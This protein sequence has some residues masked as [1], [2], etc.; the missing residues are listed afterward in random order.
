[1]SSFKSYDLPENYFNSRFGT[2]I[3]NLEKYETDELDRFAMFSH[4]KNAHLTIIGAGGI[5]SHLAMLAATSGMRKI[6]IID[7][8][9]VEESN[10]IRQY[11][12][13]ESEVH[14]K[15]KGKALSERIKEVNSHCNVEVI[16]AYVNTEEKAN[17]YINNC[18]LV[19]QTAD[20][21]RGKLNR[22]INNVCIKKKIPIIFSLNNTIGPLYIPGKTGCYECM[23]QELMLTKPGIHERLNIISERQ[24][25]KS[26]PSSPNG[27]LMT[28]YYLYEEMIKFLIGREDLVTF[29][30]VLR[31][32]SYPNPVTSFEFSIDK[33]CSCRKYKKGAAY[34]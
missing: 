12:Y 21:P 31:L 33:K 24:P 15:R 18:S 19:I 1:M 13:H 22:F 25:S 17:E 10:L 8:D 4:I 3:A 7:G 2:F 20:Q 14:S 23:E 30:G 29:N 27:S 6:T 34:D 26:W 32:G 11:F 9:I 5:G 16:D 28:V